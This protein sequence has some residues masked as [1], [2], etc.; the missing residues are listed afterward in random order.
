MCLSCWYWFSFKID[1]WYL[2]LNIIDNLL[3]CVC[4]MLLMFVIFEEGIVMF[5]CGLDEVVI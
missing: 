3:C 5:V 1:C 2:S 4:D